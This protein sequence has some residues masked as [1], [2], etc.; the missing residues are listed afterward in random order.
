MFKNYFKTAWRNLGKS[1][2]HSFI[3]IAGLSI[4]MSVAIL[5]GL[6]I[7]DE[8]SFNK[9]FENYDHIAQVIQNVT[10]NGEVQTWNNVPYPLSAELRTNYGS[11]FKHIVM[12]ANWGDHI[13]TVND[14]KL[15]SNGGYFEKEMPEMFSLKMVSGNWKSLNETASVLLSAS[16]AKAYFGDENPINK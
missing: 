16:T 10:N 3:N 8:V 5:I 9:N 2:M 15:K 14:K 1:K 6:W 7:F 11:D 12:A 13:I 4:G